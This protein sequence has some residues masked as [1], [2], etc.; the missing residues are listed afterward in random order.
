[1]PRGAG[2]AVA[3]PPGE[4]TIPPRLR[5]GRRGRLLSTTS[6]KVEP[7]KTPR[8]MARPGEVNVDAQRVTGT[9]A[10]ASFRR[11]ANSLPSAL[12]SNLYGPGSI[13]ASGL[14]LPTLWCLHAAR[15]RRRV[16]R[17]A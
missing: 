1:M 7:T 17:S 2:D 15:E 3:S 5:F 13:R 9:R 14:R 4:R 12:R 16:R 11:P 6:L 10:C 8:R